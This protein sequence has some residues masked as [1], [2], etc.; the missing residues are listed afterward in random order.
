MPFCK[1]VKLTGFYRCALLT[2]I[3]VN[4]VHGWACACQ[5]KD[6]A[7]Q[8]FTKTQQEMGNASVAHAHTPIH[9]TS[10]LSIVHYRI[11]FL[12][13]IFFFKCYLVLR[14][15]RTCHLDTDGQVTC[16]CPQGYEGR[17]C[18]KCASGYQGNPF[19]PGDICRPGINCF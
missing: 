3:V 8:V 13:S 11:D 18:E 12:T 15:A 7:L 14:F 9:L 2:T 1:I 4:M 10:K 16:D 5:K 6:P 17:R 19:I